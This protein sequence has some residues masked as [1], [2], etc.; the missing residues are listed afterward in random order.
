MNLDGWDHFFGLRD[1][2]AAQPDMREVA[3]MARE[4]YDGVIY[5]V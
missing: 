1:D 4:L 5:F 3:R 2:P